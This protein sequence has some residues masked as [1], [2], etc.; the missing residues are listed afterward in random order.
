MVPALVHT[1]NFI[2]FPLL[3]SGNR[4]SS[5][6]LAYCFSCLSR[7]FEPKVPRKPKPLALVV[8]LIVN[9]LKELADDTVTEKTYEFKRF[10]LVL[11]LP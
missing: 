8:R 3:S 5:Y 10:E 9:D 6:F 2:G 1:K 7:Y 4:F 11:D